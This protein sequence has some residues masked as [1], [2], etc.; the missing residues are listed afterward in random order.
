VPP[1]FEDLTTSNTV[2]VPARE[3]LFADTR[4]SVS[5]LQR[6]IEA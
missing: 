2:I 4:D 1:V 5:R 6:W 3:A